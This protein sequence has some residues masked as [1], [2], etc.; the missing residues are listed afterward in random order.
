MKQSWATFFLP[1][2]STAWDKAFWVRKKPCLLV[3]VLKDGT[4]V[5]GIYG[6]NSPCLV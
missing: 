2:P 6:T 5:R 3:I 4:I 1:L